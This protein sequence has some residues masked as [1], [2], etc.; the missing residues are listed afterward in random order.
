MYMCIISINT[1][2]LY[3]LV[4]LHTDRVVFFNIYFIFLLGLRSR[5]EMPMLRDSLIILQ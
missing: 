5:G 1:I 2:F 4:L 3:T